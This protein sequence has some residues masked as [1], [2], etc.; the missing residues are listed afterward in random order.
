MTLEQVGYATTFGGRLL[1]MFPNTFWVDWKYIGGGVTIPAPVP[2]TMPTGAMLLGFVGG[3]NAWML[4]NEDDTFTIG[5]DA[6]GG[7]EYTLPTGVWPMG[8]FGGVAYLMDGNTG[9]FYW[10]DGTAAPVLITGGTPSPQGIVSSGWIVNSDDDWYKLDTTT[11]AWIIVTPPTGVDPQYAYPNI[12]T[13]DTLVWDG[14]GWHHLS[15]AGV[16]TAVASGPTDPL[17]NTGGA[18]YTDTEIWVASS[19]PGNGS[20]WSPGDGWRTDHR[21]Y[22]YTQMWGLA[23]G[24]VWTDG[25]DYWRTKL[26][27]WNTLPTPDPLLGFDSFAGDY[28]RVVGYNSQ[29]RY[30]GYWNQGG[31]WVLGLRERIYLLEQNQT[32][33]ENRLFALENP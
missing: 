28:D 3:D 26:G 15:P 29:D 16:W 5:G 11:G 10:T 4:P 9:E 18:T 27:G 1:V 24:A 30:W 25:T 8:V 19:T 13:S 33:I 12:E 20:W 6:H 21:N 14:T 7:W 2:I 22:P 31:P 23:D 17:P 32:T